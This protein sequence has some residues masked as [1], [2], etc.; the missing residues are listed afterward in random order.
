MIT[1][2]YCPAYVNDALRDTWTPTPWMVD[3]FDRDREQEINTWLNDNLGREHIPHLSREGVW[4]KSC[5]TIDGWTW[6]GF[7][8]EEHLEQF[9][10]AF[11]SAFPSPTVVVREV[12][13]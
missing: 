8:T 4:H 9:K 7:A 12:A 2:K 13:Q 5:V 3:V 10:V 6:Y 1:R 11:R